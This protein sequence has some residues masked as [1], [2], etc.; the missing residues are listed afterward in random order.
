MS[1]PR[2]FEVK[3]KRSGAGRMES[4][5]ITLKSLGLTRFG[6][7]IFV[8]DTPAIRGMLYKVVHLL[9]VTPHEGNPPPTSARARARARAKA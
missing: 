4:Q 5:R 6:K 8:K 2:H 9:E 3:L 7:T 1:A